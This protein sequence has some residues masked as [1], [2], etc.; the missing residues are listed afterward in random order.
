MAKWQRGGLSQHHLAKWRG[1]EEVTQLS[2]KQLHEGST[3]SRASRIT[4]LLRGAGSRSCSSAE[5]DTYFWDKTATRG[6][7]SLPHLHFSVM[8]PTLK[9]LLLF[10]GIAVLVVAGVF[11]FKN[12]KTVSKNA[13]LL[14]ETPHTKAEAFLDDQ[15][16]GP[17][18][19]QKDDLSAG[20]YNL[21]LISGEQIYQTRIELLSGA[22]TTIRREFGPSDTFSSGDVFW[23]EKTGESATI[24]ITSD[25]DGVKVKVDG[26]D[27][28]ETPILLEEIE[29]G[30]HDLHLSFENFETRSFSIRVEDGH[31][32]RISSKLALAP[33]P[34][35]GFEEITFGG[36]S[37]TVYNLS[38]SSTSLFAD[39]ASLAKG[40]IYWT[41][42]RGLGA[43]QI[44][45]DYFVD[46]AGVVYDSEGK[47][48]DPNTFAG[49]PVEA[50]AV[51]YLGGV[52]DEDLS[53]QAKPLLT[54]LTEKVLKTPPLVGKAKILPTGVG[55]LRVRSGAS[56]SADEVTKVNV[57]EKFLILEEGTGWVKIEVTGEQEGWVSS[58]Y[59]EKIQEA[60]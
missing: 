21:K 36:E 24:S 27:V 57:G 47:V 17:T 30:T 45:L 43:A 51:G 2:A 9:P 49:E 32:L 26:R 29:A 56:L 46:S 60:P 53:D 39:A 16:L 11:V 3:P 55:W 6:F 23:F 31:Q 40:I 50:V 13:S 5:R 44:K 25:P 1:G 15:S 54:S 58:D 22:Q 10:A 8:K 19:L 33:L 38:P 4:I 7:D 59:V 12:F 37:V 28:G 42:T 52:G 34:A 14:I 35:D 48:F 20:T 18:P 41:R